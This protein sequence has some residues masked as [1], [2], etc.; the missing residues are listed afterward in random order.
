MAATLNLFPYILLYYI[1]VYRSD[2]LTLH[3]KTLLGD[4]RVYHGQFQCWRRISTGIL[5]LSYAWHHRPLL[6]TR[7]LTPAGVF[8]SNIPATKWTK[9]GQTALLVPGHDPPIDIKIY[10]DVHPQPGPTNGENTAII[11]IGRLTKTS[12]SMQI[13]VAGKM[14]YSRSELLAIR[15]QPSVMLPCERTQLFFT[16]KDFGLFRYRGKRGGKRKIPTI[17]KYRPTND[18]E[19]GHV[20]RVAT[21]ARLQRTRNPANLTLVTTTLAGPTKGSTTAFVPSFLVSN[22]MSLA[23]KIDELRLFLQNANL[24]CVCITESWL[25]SH[26]HD[27][28][29]ALKGFNII[30][31]DRAESEQGGV[32][33]YVK[34]AIKFTILDD[35]HDP[36]FEMLWIKLRPT[37]LPRGCTS[38]VVVTL[39]HPPSAS[40]LAIVEYLTKCLSIIESRFAN[41]GF[42][43]L[44]DFNRL[45]ITPL[46][47]NFQLKQIVHFPTRGR[48]TLDLILTN[49]SEYYQAPIERPPFGL[50]DHATIELQPK[51]RAH[52][53]QTTITIKARDLRPSKRH[54]MSSCLE[55]VDVCAMTSA[56]ETC[57]EK[58]SLLE[59]IMTTG[60]D[61]ILP[62]QSRRVHSTEPPWITSTLKKL[63]QARQR[64]LSRGDNQQFREF[65]NRVNRERKACRAKYFKA[66]V[67]HLKECKPSA[68]WTEVKKL[69]GCS[70]AFTERSYVTTSL[71]HLYGPTDNVNLANIINKAFLSPM[72]SFTPIP[73]DYVTDPANSATQ[74]LG[75]VVSKESVFKKLIKLN[76]TKAH[77]PDGIPGW[78]LKENADLL[79]GPIADILNSSY[80][81][82]RLPPSLSQCLSKNLC[83]T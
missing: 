36:S 23:P 46:R 27:N 48:R 51:E 20:H 71:Q 29:V 83:R 32:C 55:A 53:K 69:S 81:E 58:V 24:D 19:Q 80:R 56:L 6:T 30:R 31:K 39:H 9:H 79:A 43:V 67:E 8:A 17:S 37:R 45:D 75:L 42:L 26:I 34:D 52:I 78:V 21:V 64:A 54:A 4:P 14:H 22:V 49:I 57:V 73:A 77:G 1:A 60:L 5:Q 74:Q 41:C 28:V 18:P 61:R 68:W 47:N 3:Q 66:K 2:C 11:S 65:R 13:P 82:G 10:M 12:S 38:I 35:L 76:R 7:N 50:S 40:D 33:V 44:G 25:R 72:R 70:P 62:I 63:I 16:L 59:E 15:R